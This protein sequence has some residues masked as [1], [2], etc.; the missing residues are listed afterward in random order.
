MTDRT[1]ISRR[2]VLKLGAGAAALS[3]ARG[4]QAAT[5]PRAK[6]PNVLLLMADQ[7][8]GDCVGADGN[9]AIH[10]PNIDRI[11][12][13]GMLFRS[14]YSTTPT[15]TPARS[16]LLSGLGPWR[17]GMLGYG[18]VAKR[19]P[20]ELPRAMRDAGYYTMGIGKMHWH[21][22][23][24]AHG[25]HKVLLDES[26]RVQSEGF[27]SD[28]RAWFAAEAPD[29]DPDVT[30]I[31][32]NDHR[33]KAYDLPERLHPTSWTGESAVQFLKT[34][35]QDSPFFLKVSFARPHSPYDPPERFMRQYADA[36]L[37]KAVVG[38]WADRYAPRS[39][40]QPTLWHGDLGA[41]LVR[42]ARQGYYGSISFID[43]QVGRIFEVLEKR[44]LFDDTLIIFTADHGDMTG[45]HH[46][47]RK[48]YAYEASARIPMLMRW[49]TGL[50][51]GE[52]GQVSRAPV[53]LR[54]IL[55]TFLD[56]AGAPG[57]ETLDGRT[58][59]D[60]AR[61]NA[62]DWR[63]YIDLEHD[64]CYS[65]SNHWNALTD[66]REK[67]IFHA[68]DGEEQ[69]FNLTDDPGECTDLAGDP[70]HADT[71]RMWRGR[72]VEHLAERGDKFVS[73]GKLA[74]R[75]ERQLYSP[76]HPDSPAKA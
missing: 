12:H 75:P 5:T 44:G 60:L 19:Y 40:D 62:S 76:H 32:F 18:K 3:C 26:G 56:A 47:W 42:S 2:D 16:G 27:Q 25:F 63:P 69:L 20:I 68:R 35:D 15:C 38:G 59:L 46:M 71:L 50:A 36:D 43:E 64:V 52:R 33:S 57:A 74:L 70:A 31:G 21:P 49:P 39:S 65:P 29:L 41:E 66:G 30:G 28:Y 53:E 7:Y 34:Y 1:Q 73:N 4:V 8:R 37:P 11:G 23:R 6:R 24:N 45:D 17:H 22:Q 67:Y 14:A 48:S 55:P 61:G 58:M 10:T 72:M 9:A 51:S 54:D 13:E